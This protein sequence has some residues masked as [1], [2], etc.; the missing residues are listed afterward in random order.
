MNQLG[1]S[2]LTVLLGIF[3]VT[4]G[5]MNA[6]LGQQ[7]GSAFLAS[8][9][10]LAIGFFLSLSV[11]IFQL[12]S[13][14]LKSSLEGIPWYNWVGGGLFSFSAVSLFYFLIPRQGIAS[15]VVISLSSQLLYAMLAGSMGWFDLP[16]EAITPRKVL[17][18]IALLGSV[19][20][21]KS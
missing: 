5:S 12:S 11:L 16:V 21:L 1:L 9:I 18:V 6:R 7:T 3:I 19:I 2:L 20:L 14:N 13:R 4:Q 10:S 15:T 17:G 8:S